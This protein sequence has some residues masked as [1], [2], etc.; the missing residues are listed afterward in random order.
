MTGRG[1]ISY[2]SSDESERSHSPTVREICDEFEG[3]YR[4]TRSRTGA[5]RPVNYQRLAKGITTSD[6]HSA[7]AES[8]SSSSVGAQEVSVYMAGNLEDIAK[9]VNEHHVMLQAQQETLLQLKDMLV[10]VLTE[11][12]QKP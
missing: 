5:I 1:K 2:P 3:V 6:E 7:I 9:R 11:K 12:G 4:H 8:Q 10:Q